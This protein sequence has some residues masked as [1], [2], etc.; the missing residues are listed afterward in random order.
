MLCCSFTHSCVAV[1]DF[2]QRPPE[3]RGKTAGQKR[4]APQSNL[5]PAKRPKRAAA[6]AKKNY[7]DLDL[8]DF[9]VDDSGDDDDDGGIL[10]REGTVCQ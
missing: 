3:P 4:A 6:A 2:P 9:I 7:A 10:S 1:Q 5:I 8:E